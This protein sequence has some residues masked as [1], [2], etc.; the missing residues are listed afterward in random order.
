M[1]FRAIWKSNF[2]PMAAALALLVTATL[3]VAIDPSVAS[4][5]SR[6]VIESPFGLVG[7]DAKVARA[8][9]Y[10]VVTLPDG[11]LASVPVAKA[12][13]A[14][15]GTY[16]P[17]SGILEPV[18]NSSGPSTNDYQELPG[19][20]G[21]SYVSLNSTGNQKANLGTGFFISNSGA[22]LPWQ[23]SWHV[24]I[25]DNGGSSQQNY[26]EGGGHLAGVAW[27]GHTRVLGLTRGYATAKVTTGSFTITT[28][29][30]ICFSAGPQVTEF[31]S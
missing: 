26:S 5:H 19:E 13:A 14:R 18:K 28:H 15:A 2:W 29:G 12:A 31:I 23:V 6:K 11:S 22:G 1:S 16:V 20:C 27:I 3:I 9:G 8:H 4:A 17:V 24:A 7:F 30:W 25:V 21:S 10:E